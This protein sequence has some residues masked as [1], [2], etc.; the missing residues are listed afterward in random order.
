[1][2]NLK[3]K[4]EE[5]KSHIHYGAEDEMLCFRKNDLAVAIELIL[6]EMTESNTKWWRDHGALHMNGEWSP[7]K[8]SEIFEEDEDYQHGRVAAV[9]MAMYTLAET[10]NVEELKEITV[11]QGDDKEEETF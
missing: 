8:T 10:F 2:K 5:R 7:L 11:A 9:E 6:E 1:M 3:E 4:V